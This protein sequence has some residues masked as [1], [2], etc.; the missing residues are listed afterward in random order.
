[1][2]P[3]HPPTGPVCE[4]CHTTVHWDLFL[5]GVSRASRRAD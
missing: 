3:G 1:M 4:D 2:T 5:P